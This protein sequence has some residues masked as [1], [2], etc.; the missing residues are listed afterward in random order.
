MVKKLD[1]DELSRGFDLFSDLQIF[2]ARIPGS[3]RMIMHTVYVNAQIE[4]VAPALADF[5]L[6][7]IGAP[8]ITRSSTDD[9]AP[10]P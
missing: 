1:A 5:H 10:P 7:G 4:L 2:E 6:L 8:P 3:R 9:I